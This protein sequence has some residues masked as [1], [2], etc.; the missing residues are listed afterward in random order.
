MPIVAIAVGHPPCTFFL[1]FGP[2][3]ICWYSSCPSQTDMMSASQVWEAYETLFFQQSIANFASVKFYISILLVAFLDGNPNTFPRWSPGESLPFRRHPNTDSLQGTFTPR[4][5][6]TRSFPSAV[7]IGGNEDRHP[8]LARNYV[9]ERLFVA[10]L[11]NCM[12][13]ADTSY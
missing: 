2:S 7:R 4:Q 1:R 5:S 11:G 13:C 3:S 10:M 12:S 8:A 6:L 9:W